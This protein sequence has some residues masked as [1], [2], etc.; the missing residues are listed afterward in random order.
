VSEP[1]QPILVLG[2]TGHYGHAIVRYLLDA[3]QLVRVLSR[4][5]AAAR[6]LLD[7]RVEVLEGDITAAASREQALAG[8]RAAVIAVSAFSRAAIRRRMAIERDGV[9]AV[10]EAAARVGV[11]RVVALSGYEMRRD[12]IERHGFQEFAR[13]MLDV[14]RALEASQLDW[15][16]LGCGVSMEIFF[17]TLRGDR[18]MV[19]GGGPPGL[20]VVS[21]Q[22]VGAIT[23]QAVLRDDLGGLRFRVPG[24]EA[25]S[26]PEAAARISKVWGRP[27]RVVSVPLTL[28]KIA[29]ALSRPFTPFVGQLVLAATLMNNFPQDLVAEVPADHQRLRDTFD[30]APTTLE[31]EAQRRA[32]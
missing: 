3:G 23:A 24:P 11:R 21:Q 15:T 7:E 29:A 2:G 18:M 13:P 31:M 9:L 5:T 19:P 1:R 17:A 16:I 20:P 14:Q 22:D 12:L 28:L 30:Y 10:L 4:D 8:A 32:K 6:A 26:F 25:I 27:L